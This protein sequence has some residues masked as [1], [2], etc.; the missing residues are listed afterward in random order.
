M[1]LGEVGVSLPW[2]CHPLVL[3]APCY[4]R[5]FL[6]LVLLLQNWKSKIHKVSI[7]LSN[8]FNKCIE[9]S[10]ILDFQFGNNNTKFRKSLQ[11]PRARRTRGWHHHGSDTPT[12][13]RAILLHTDQFF[14]TF[15]HTTVRV[16]HLLIYCKF[17][18][19][20]P[21][22]L[23][24]KSTFREFYKGV[25]QIQQPQT[26]SIFWKNHCWYRNKRYLIWKP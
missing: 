24:V 9:T 3:L 8:T 22:P 12:S 19:E 16:W 11:W 4:W 2:W 15:L 5:L 10:R 26:F 14:Y 13:P 17:Y 6:N 21:R 23:A 7:L 18:M 25:E 1:A 20:V